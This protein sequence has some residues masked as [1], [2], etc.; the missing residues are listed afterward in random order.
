MLQHK[1][2][3]PNTA[4][5]QLCLDQNKTSTTTPHPGYLFRKTV[6]T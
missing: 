5:K 2:Y 6:V 3:H 1:K 4:Y